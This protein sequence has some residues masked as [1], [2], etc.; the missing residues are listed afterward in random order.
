MAENHWKKS[1]NRKS[2]KKHLDPGA[3][4]FLKESEKCNWR[5][6]MKNWR[7]TLPLLVSF[8]AVILKS[9]SFWE[10]MHEIMRCKFSGARPKSSRWSGFGT[11]LIRFLLSLCALF[12]CIFTLIVQGVENFCILTFSIPEIECKMQDFFRGTKPLISSNYNF[13]KGLSKLIL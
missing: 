5:T 7:S 12:Q 13:A 1:S 6:W 2:A 11:F 4:L 10:E 3:L 9:F 8:L